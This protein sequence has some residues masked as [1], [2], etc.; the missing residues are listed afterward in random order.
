M[1]RRK[2]PTTPAANRATKASAIVTTMR[3]RRIVMVVAIVILAGGA[4]VVAVLA[5]I[6]LSYVMSG[7]PPAEC[8]NEDPLNT[9]ILPRPLMM[10]DAIGIVSA[11]G[12]LLVGA[13]WALLGDTIRARLLRIV[14]AI[15]LAFL[16]R[17]AAAVV[18]AALL[19]TCL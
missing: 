17:F 13:G 14:V 19:P 6:V 3:R 11:G 1:G 16:A 7:S 18:G 4:Y 15:A 8:F 2:A 10:G 5:A 9:I 12:T